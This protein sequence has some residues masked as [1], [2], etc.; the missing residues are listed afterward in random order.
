MKIL[1]SSD[2]KKQIKRVTNSSNELVGLTTSDYSFNFFGPYKNRVI[3]TSLE[4]N[5]AGTSFGIPFKK[6]FVTMMNDIIINPTI[7]YIDF[8]INTGIITCKKLTKAQQN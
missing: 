5:R 1:G 2:N 3:N 8:N 6:R 4:Q 7:S